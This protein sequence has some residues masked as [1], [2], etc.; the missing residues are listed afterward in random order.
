M[1]YVKCKQNL[2]IF[3]VFDVFHLFPVTR[4]SEKAG[5]ISDSN[6]RHR[7]EDIQT[8]MLF[9]KAYR[10]G[11]TQGDK[12]YYR[13]RYLI[14]ESLGS[15]C[16]EY[17]CEGTYNMIRREYARRIVRRIYT[18]RQPGAEVMSRHRIRPHR[19]SRRICKID[20]IRNR[21]RNDEILHRHLEYINLEQTRI[22]EKE[23]P[24]RI[25]EC[26]KQYKTLV[27]RYDIIKFT[28]YL[29]EV[30]QCSSLGNKENISMNRKKK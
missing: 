21:K 3:D 14:R 10:Y 12:K 7:S 17:N 24:E 20:H 13:K 2:R 9:Y 19:M 27:K 30:G 26:V 8:R 5:K 16:S 6:N 4:F 23:Y 1:C 18:F 25:P 22:Y 11:D 15:P 29:M 28:V